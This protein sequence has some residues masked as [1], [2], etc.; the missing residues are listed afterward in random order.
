M[1]LPKMAIHIEQD[2]NQAQLAFQLQSQA[3]LGAIRLMESRVV[4]KVAPEDAQFPL[5]IALKHQVEDA[6][7][8]SHK[9]TIPI[10]FG[11]KAI[12]ADEKTDVL[13]ITCRFE[14]TYVLAETYEPTPEQIDA[15]R[16]GNAIFNCWSYFREYVQNSVARM[17]YPP[18]TIPF[19]RMVP[20]PIS[21]AGKPHRLDG[22]T[23]KLEP[24]AEQAPEPKPKRRIKEG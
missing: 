3:D 8:S 15:F 18:V 17:N 13:V 19:L 20:K 14:A 23:A 1:R 12:T 16:Q 7:V 6:V 10:R 11:F 21:A 9:M 24:P 22:G 2:K 4:C 5:S